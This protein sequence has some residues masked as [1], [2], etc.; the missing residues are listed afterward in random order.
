MVRQKGLE[1]PTFWFV[2]KHS[3]QLSYWRIAF[4]TL[5]Y[6]ST[7]GEEMQVLFLKKPEKIFHCRMYWRPE[8]TAVACERA[9]KF[10]F[11]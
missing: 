4:L 8:E 5:R 10:C 1:P 7:G 3:I 11:R 2:A 9:E 6:N